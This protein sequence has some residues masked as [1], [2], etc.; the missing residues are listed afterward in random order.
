[1]SGSSAT[2]KLVAILL[3]GI[4][5]GSGVGYFYASSNYEPRITSYQE[6]VT[7]L[8]GQVTTLTSENTAQASQITSL[9]S[10]ISGLETTITQK[11]QEITTL[12]GTV[13]S[14]KTQ[15]VGL[16]ADISDYQEQ[17]DT[18][19]TQF[20]L[21]DGYLRVAAYDWSLQFPNGMY[22]RLKGITTGTSATEETGVV[23]GYFIYDNV[24]TD[25]IEVTYTNANTAPD[26]D[27]TIMEKI[28]NL[29]SYIT[30]TDPKTS[31]TISGHAARY[32][33]L[34]YDYSGRTYYVVVAAWYC[35]TTQT[36][37]VYYR[38]ATTA[39]STPVF[40]HF[41][42]TFACHVRSVD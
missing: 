3:A 2:I 38:E 33:T 20:L 21:S 13:S 36:T 27:N 18:L 6:Q 17:V 8:T 28:T 37:Y 39:S 31:T 10:E 32:E 35:T 9:D 15:V 40:E 25:W 42:D 16:E 12:E 34:T 11:N 41:V 23:Y 5:V 7:T 1:M 24:I 14:Y 4:V 26:L 30:S 19:Q 22:T 29:S